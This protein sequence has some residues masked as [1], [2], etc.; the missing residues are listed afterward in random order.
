VEETGHHHSGS[1]QDQERDLRVERAVGFA[2]SKAVILI[3]QIDLE[4]EFL[5]AIRNPPT[6]VDRFSKVFS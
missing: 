1:P 5:L 6:L 2:E 4:K 3:I